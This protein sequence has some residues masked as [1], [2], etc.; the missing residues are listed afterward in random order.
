MI[1]LKYFQ[2]YFVLNCYFKLGIKW[3]CGVVIERQDVFEKISLAIFSDQMYQRR[4][5]K[6]SLGNRKKCGALRCATLF[7]RSFSD[8]FV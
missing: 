8:T 2:I 6:I 1:L 3:T 4:M 5:E 7:M